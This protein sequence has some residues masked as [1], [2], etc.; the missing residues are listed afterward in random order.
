MGARSRIMM[1]CVDLVL[2]DKGKCC[3]RCHKRTPLP[4]CFCV[5]DKEG[6]K[7]D[8]E[9]CC[10]A[11]GWASKAYQML[12]IYRLEGEEMGEHGP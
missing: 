6:C 4:F 10:E 2:W 5:E 11:A 1:T 12:H 3:A 9:L 7:L 8:L